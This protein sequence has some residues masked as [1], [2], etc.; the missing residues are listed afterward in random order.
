V[1]HS[2]SSRTAS[3]LLVSVDACNKNKFDQRN[4]SRHSDRDHGMSNVVL[5]AP[6]TPTTEGAGA[7]ELLPRK[8]GVAGESLISIRDRL[9][10]VLHPGNWKRHRF[11]YAPHP[12]VALSWVLKAYRR[13]SSGRDASNTRFVKPFWNKICPNDWPHDTGMST[14]VTSTDLNSN[15]S[16]RMATSSLTISSIIDLRRPPCFCQIS[17]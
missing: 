15:C 12:K 3:R 17:T 1:V 8:P 2:K 16:C 7:R 9:L 10:R 14:I 6:R 13:Q 5:H 11:L 4:N